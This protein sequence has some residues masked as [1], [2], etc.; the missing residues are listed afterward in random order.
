MRISDWSSDVC[1]SDLPP[2]VRVSTASGNVPF[3]IPRGAKLDPL[4]VERALNHPVDIDAG[5]MN[6]IG[7]EA[8][9]RHDLLDLRDRH[10]AGSRHVGIEVTSGLSIDEISFRISL[11]RLDDREVSRQRSL[12]DEEISVELLYWFSFRQDRKRKSVV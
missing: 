10:S 5:R 12:T 4:V 11:P 2:S 8:S 6:M 3:S 1:S 7:I 9:S